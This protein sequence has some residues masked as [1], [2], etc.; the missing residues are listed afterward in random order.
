[1]ARKRNVYRID[2][3]LIR[4]GGVALAVGLLAYGCSDVPD[5]AAVLD[6]WQYLL[7]IGG[8]VML[9][10]GHVVRRDERQIARVWRIL[11]QCTEV[12]IDEL[13]QATGH[14]RTFL[15]RALR[16][17]NGQPGAYYVWDDAA[18]TIVDGRMRSHV[19]VVERCESCGAA[20]HAK[21][22]MDI[23]AVP[24]CDH[25]GAPVTAKDLNRLKQEQV[26]ALRA[27]LA[28]PV[29]QLSIPLLLLLL[30]IFWPAGVLYALWSTGVFDQ[31]L[32]RVRA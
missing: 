31:L 8:V 4:A 7:L 29:H 6:V 2:D 19:V 10:V 28:R 26:Q 22:S 17:I 5:G 21:L 15:L 23:P 30:L 16:T 12:R 9:M 1:M 14:S 18:G 3:W 11:D 20:V 27:E 13:Q 24:T 32:S 25:C